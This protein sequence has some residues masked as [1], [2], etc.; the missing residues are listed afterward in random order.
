MENSIETS[1]SEKSLEAFEKKVNL[2]Q[3]HKRSISWARS[4]VLFFVL[5]AICV[6]PFLPTFSCKH[7]EVSGNYLLTKDTILK[8]GGYSSSTPLILVNE[9]A[10]VERLEEKEYIHDVT[11][12]WSLFD[13][14]L[15]VD[16][17]AAVL[18]E[19]QDDETYQYWLSSDETYAAFQKRYPESQYDFQKEKTPSLISDLSV[20]TSS[21]RKKVLQQLKTIAMPILQQAQFFDIEKRTIT[22]PDAERSRYYFGFYFLG[23]EQGDTP[24]YY[25]IA[26]TE[27]AFDYFLMPER[28][29]EEIATIAKIED[30]KVYNHDT[31]TTLS[32][33]NLVCEYDGEEN[34]C[35]LL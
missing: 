28:F 29:E 27:D 3:K 33:V 32:Y 25:R 18:K 20:L 35:H 9:K 22:Y 1:V 10:F 30:K 15:L 21:L 13:C 6:F 24:L 12:H 8:M 2:Q 16:E 5:I 7:M 23:K 11:L 31:I 26:M 17:V 14:S 4:M 19:K 34:A